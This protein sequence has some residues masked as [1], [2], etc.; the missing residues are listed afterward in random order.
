[1]LE[2][3]QEEEMGFDTVGEREEEQGF[4]GR[5]RIVALLAWLDYVDRM[6]EAANPTVAIALSRHASQELLRSRLEPALLQAFLCL[7]P[8]EA[9]SS[10]QT[11]DSSYDMYLRD[12][13]KQY[14]GLEEVCKTWGWPSKV[15]V[16]PEF[17]QQQ[18]EF[19]EGSFLR[20][21]FS[22]V[23]GMLDQSH[24]V[25][26]LVTGLAARLALI[27]HPALHE[28]LLDPFLSVSP[29]VHTLC[30][31]LKKVSAEIE[32]YMKSEPEFGQKL[33]LARKQLLGITYNIQK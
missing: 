24:A 12:A 14:A 13:H 1:M 23:E 16:L 32:A 22:K 5:R 21:L 8:E 11:A 17:Q 3:L 2:I 33:L 26:L 31:T 9:K 4:T 28:F 6:A 15:K 29:G 19:Y 27:P 18:E 25:N 7:L 10:Y 30:T 20:M